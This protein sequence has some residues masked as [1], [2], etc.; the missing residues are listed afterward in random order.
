MKTGEAQGVTPRLL[1]LLL[2]QKAH[3]LAD[4]HCSGRMG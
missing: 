2:L 1:F 3:D 4:S